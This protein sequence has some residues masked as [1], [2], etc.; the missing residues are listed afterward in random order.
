M[1]STIGEFISQNINV[2]IGLFTGSAI[3]WVVLSKILFTLIIT[4]ES[5]KKIVEETEKGIDK[6]AKKDKNLAYLMAV[7]MEESGRQL[8]ALGSKKKKEYLP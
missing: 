2:I 1:L 4:P 7:D 5:I 3:I 6:I 8:Q